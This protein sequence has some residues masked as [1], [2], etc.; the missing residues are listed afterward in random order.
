MSRPCFCLALAL[1]LCLSPAGYAQTSAAAPAHR[2]TASH[3]SSGEQKAIRAFHDTEQ[4]P[5]QLRAFIARMPKGADLHMHLSGAIYAETFI[6]DAAADHLCY[7]PAARRIFKPSA[8]T[9]SLT[10]KPVC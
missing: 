8:T 4:N 7:S 5:L 3:A 9:R 1:S 2:H 10:P 6:K